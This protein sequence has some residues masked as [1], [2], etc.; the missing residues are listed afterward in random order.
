VFDAKC[1]GWQALDRRKEGSAAPDR[2]RID[3]Q[4]VLVDHIQPG[5][6]LHEPHAAVC[7]DVS[8]RLG[9][10]NVSRVSALMSM[11]LDG[12]AAD[13]VRSSSV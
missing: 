5:K 12:F 1:S 4:P 10:R 8:A 7:H 11:S 2:D 6:R 9:N 3:V 13:R